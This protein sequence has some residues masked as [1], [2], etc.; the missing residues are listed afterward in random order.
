MK[1]ET[2]EVRGYWF[3]IFGYILQI[4]KRRKNKAEN[5]DEDHSGVDGDDA[6]ILHIIYTIPIE[7]C[8][9]GDMLR[10][11]MLRLPIIGYRKE[12]YS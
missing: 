11:I 9:Y 10:M 12:C 1:N 3:L 5:E 2:C 4:K 8:Y 7:C 6:C